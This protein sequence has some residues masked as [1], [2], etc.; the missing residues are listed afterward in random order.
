MTTAVTTRVLQNSK[1]EYTVHLTGINS[2]ATGETDVVKIDKSALLNKVGNEP[3]SINI[4]SARWNIQGFT[5]VLIE[6]DAATDDTAMVLSGNGYDNF[7][8]AGGLRDP[9]ST[10]TV[11]D[12]LL[13]S[14]GAASAS[15][16]DI[17]LVCQLQ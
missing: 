5:Y 3:L 15:T 17:T 9:R 16:Y 4:M 7:E 11:G 1:Y 6:W 14:V 10:T 12:I 2:D 13:T 8:A